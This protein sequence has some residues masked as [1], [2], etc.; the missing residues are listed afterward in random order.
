MHNDCLEIKFPFS[1]DRLVTIEL[2]PQS[3][4]VKFGDKFFMKTG[5]DGTLY[6]PHDH[7]YNAQV[8]RQMAILGIKWR[9]CVVY[10][11][12][13]IVVDCILADNSHWDHLSNK[14]IF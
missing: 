3:I 11:N 5:E 1:I 14:L 2:S 7:K 9:D 4:T 13:E 6:L 8:Q 10:S 12:G